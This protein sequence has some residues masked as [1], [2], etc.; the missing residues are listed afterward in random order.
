MT[1][2]VIALLVGVVMPAAAGARRAAP[3]G[4][5]AQI[6]LAA[7]GVTKI[8]RGRFARGQ[9]GPLLRAVNNARRL[10]GRRRPALCPT[11]AAT[12]AAISRLGLPSTWRLRRAPVPRGLHCVCWL[13][14]R[15]HC[16]A[17]PDAAAP[18]PSAT[19]RGSSRRRAE[20]A[21]PLCPR[22]LRVPSRARERRSLWV[23]STLR[24][25]SAARPD[26]GL[27]CTRSRRRPGTATRRPTWPPIPWPSSAAPTSV[28]RPGPPA[29]RSP[30]RPRV[31]AWRGSPGTPRTRSPPTRDGRSR[32]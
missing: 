14:P 21:L 18:R 28:F 2:F 20:A 27:T 5:K 25:R 24:S 17:G 30:P 26:R 3:A 4:P 12:D 31:A 29:P 16:C 13:E 11:A 6:T 8:A 22:P 23:P 32:P 19:P 9:R 7:H 10:S 15:R 1:T